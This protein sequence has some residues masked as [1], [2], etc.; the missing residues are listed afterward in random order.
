GPIVAQLR[1]L[2]WVSSVLAPISLFS[3][4]DPPVPPQIPALYQLMKRSP[5]F[6]KLLIW[7]ATFKLDSLM[8]PVYDLRAQ[9]G[10]PRGAQPIFAGQH[11]PRL[12][13]AL[14]SQLLAKPQRDWP[15]PLV[16][17]GFPFYD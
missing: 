15:T 9:L 12:V 2:P 7:I 14:F 11:S 6:T 4:Y 13:L 3:I 1:G 16:V 5:A 8:K 17:T 10:L